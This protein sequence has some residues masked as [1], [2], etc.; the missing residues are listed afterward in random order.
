MKLLQ[1]GVA[2]I[3]QDFDVG[4]NMHTTFFVQTKIVP[5]SI[6]KIGTNHFCRFFIDNQLRF[7][8]VSLLF[9]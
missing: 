4:M 5:L 2:A 6:R 9:P 8:G 1:T 7:Q 3:G